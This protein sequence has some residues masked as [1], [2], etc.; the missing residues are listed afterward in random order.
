MCLHIDVSRSDR[1][2]Y[3]GCRK[4]CLEASELTPL[5]TKLTFC[6]A[7]FIFL[8][9]VLIKL[10]KIVLELEQLFLKHHQK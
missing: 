2:T 4:N 3:F 10:S 9:L 8:K 1:V 5:Y 6:A 7:S